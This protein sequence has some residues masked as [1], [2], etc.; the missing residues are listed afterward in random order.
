[1]SL[2]SSQIAQHEQEAKTRH[3]YAVQHIGNSQIPGWFNELLEHKILPLLV[4]VGFD[5]EIASNIF[6]ISAPA[7]KSMGHIANPKLQLHP[8]LL[9]DIREIRQDIISQDKQEL[10][11]RVFPAEASLQNLTQL[12]QTIPTTWIILPRAHS[13]LTKSD[14]NCLIVYLQ[15]LDRE[16]NLAFEKILTRILIEFIGNYSLKF[17]SSTLPKKQM[18]EAIFYGY[19]AMFWK[20]L[21]Q[22]PPGLENSLIFRNY[23]SWAKA[24]KKRISGNDSE[25]EAVIAEMEKME[26]N[27]LPKQNT[28]TFN[29]NR[30]ANGLH[31][32]LRHG[33]AGIN[34]AVRHF[35]MN[36]PSLPGYSHNHISY[37]ILPKQISTL[38]RELRNSYDHETPGTKESIHTFLMEL[39]TAYGS[40]TIR[41]NLPQQGPPD[42][43]AFTKNRVT[44]LIQDFSKSLH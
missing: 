35:T 1:M 22:P 18:V 20:N 41:P 40:R 42:N 27:I 2:I 8:A 30:D 15:Y 23:L 13:F 37:R 39:R 36:N 9:K 32:S 11:N 34:H 38:F 16:T 12:L 25:I 43:L 44:S 10:Q 26:D 31:I 19:A 29:R 7:W 14:S 6:K 33:H 4:R 3:L 21:Q 24:F 17:I 5:K 28:R